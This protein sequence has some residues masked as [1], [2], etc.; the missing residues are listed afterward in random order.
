MIS[1]M[2][3]PFVKAN[4]PCGKANNIEASRFDGF[5]RL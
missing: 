2:M 1:A 3:L 4:F 5:Q